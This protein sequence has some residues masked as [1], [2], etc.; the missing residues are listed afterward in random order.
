M[1]G[2]SWPQEQPKL[3][4]EAQ[5]LWELGRHLVCRMPSR[6]IDTIST[7]RAFGS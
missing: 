5:L 6:E 4:S 1:S 3:T 2:V 7:P